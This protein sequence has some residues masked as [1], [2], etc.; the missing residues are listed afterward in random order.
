MCTFNSAVLIWTDG[1]C[2]YTN[3]YVDHRCPN[4]NEIILA[5]GE[6]KNFERTLQNNQISES[7]YKMKIKSGREPLGWFTR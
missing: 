7:Y 4:L 2:K 3:E 1:N 6:I 5:I